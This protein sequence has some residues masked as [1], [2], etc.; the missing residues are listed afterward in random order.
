MQRRDGIMEAQPALMDC[1]CQ[2]WVT[3]DELGRLCQALSANGD[4]GPD[5][6]CFAVV[7]NGELG[8]IKVVLGA[9]PSA[10]LKVRHTLMSLGVPGSGLWSNP[11]MPAAA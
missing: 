10:W 3:P 2:F 6:V 11:R 4:I 1:T 5:D 9:A 7:A 8:D